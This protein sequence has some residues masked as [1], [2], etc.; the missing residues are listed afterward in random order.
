MTGGRTAIDRD[1]RAL[2]VAR[3]LG[4]QEQRQRG[5]VLGLAEAARVVLDES[6]GPQLLDRL[7]ERRRALLAQ[8]LLPL[9]IGIAGVNDVHVDVVAIAELGQAFG[10]VGHGGIARA[11]NKE[12]GIR[13]ARGA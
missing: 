12:L 9:G 10:K 5:D 7:A 4:T 8:L 1:R 2:D 13:G 11:A 3:T 6:L